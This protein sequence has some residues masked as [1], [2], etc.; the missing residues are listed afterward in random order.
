MSERPEEVAAAGIVERV[1]DCQA[2]LQDTGTT[3]DQ[4][5]DYR[6]F[7]SSGRQIGVL[8]I[9]TATDPGWM[10]FYSRKQGSN[11]SFCDQRLSNSWFVVMGYPKFPRKFKSKLTREL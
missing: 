10:T 2:S 11:R 9:T 7:D 6:L 1:T 8:E 4:L 5:V 3:G